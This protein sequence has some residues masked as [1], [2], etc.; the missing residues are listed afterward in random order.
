MVDM[1]RGEG[2]TVSITSA[3]FVP[4]EMK[5]TVIKIFDYKGKIPQGILVNPYARVLDG[6]K[7]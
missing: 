2:C 1:P 7:N 3:K 4:Y 5:M 6:E